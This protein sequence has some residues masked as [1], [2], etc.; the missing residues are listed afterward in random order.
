MN[1][2]NM[3]KL[4]IREAAEKFQQALLYWKS[5]ERIRNVAAIYR[6]NWTEEDISNSIQYNIELIDPILKAFD[7]IY[8]LAV[9]GNIDEPFALTG[10]MGGKIGRVLWD[11]L[12]YPEISQPLESLTTLLKGGL[13]S[14][15]FSETDYYKL[16]LLPKKFKVE[17]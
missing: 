10:Y 3:D 15:E 12:S 14:V 11:Q 6:P 5:E 1:R 8:R 9:E 7:P 13:S 17:I 2:F 4:K 16:R